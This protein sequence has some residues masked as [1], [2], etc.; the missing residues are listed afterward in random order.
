MSFCKIMAA[1]LIALCA[2]APV[3]AEVSQADIEQIRKDMAEMRERLV[4]EK[5]AAQAETASV[6]NEMTQLKIQL[7]GIKQPDAPILHE[8]E[9]L[10]PP[11]PTIP[12]YTVTASGG[13]LQ[14]G[15]LVQAWYYAT[16]RD[17]NG[18][19]SNHAAGVV[20]RNIAA[21]Q[22]TFQVRRAELNLSIDIHEHVSAFIKA[23]LAAESDAY[24]G[25]F[26]QLSG[27]NQG[28]VKAGLNTKFGASEGSAPAILQDALINFHDIIPHHD[29]TIGQMLPYFSEDDFTPNGSLDFVERSWIGSEVARDTGAV[30]HGAWIYD[31][32]GVAYQGAGNSGRVQY[33]LSAFNSPGYY[34]D[35]AT[36]L[37][38]DDNASK[39]FLARLLVRP[40][41]SY[42][43]GHL[44]FSGAYGFGKHGSTPLN[45]A[46][47]AVNA[48][49]RVPFLKGAQPSSGQRWEAYAEYRPQCFAQG[50]WFKYEYARVRDSVAT[51]PASTG[52]FSSTAATPPDHYQPFATSGFY[53]SAGYN[54]GKM[55]DACCLPAWA[56]GLEFDARFQRYNNVW[57]QSNRDGGARVSTYFTNQATAGINY[58]IKGNYAKIQANYDIVRDPSGAHDYHFHAV[59][60]DTFS[61]NFQVMW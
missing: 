23:D 38:A 29:F 55:E 7:N 51:V 57:T 8:V 2:A 61:M 43:L 48:A 11:P 33:W 40:L 1:A 54:L 34:H 24:R 36:Q 26:A 20:D 44:E 31:G 12:N 45:Q 46:V 3:R 59:R 32:G 49:A 39:D 18:L 10:L 56:R 19:F 53:A 58:Y 14:I 25:T 4:R 17:T 13:K 41:W 42:C 47:H 50:L 16:E 27:S 60:N 22:N 30:L 15:G 6:R 37:R 5:E 21:S 35:E 9:K 52:L 28:F